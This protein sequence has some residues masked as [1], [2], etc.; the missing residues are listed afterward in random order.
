MVN[1]R[2]DFE[3]VKPFQHHTSSV[4]LKVAAPTGISHRTN[5]G[6]NSTSNRKVFPTKSSVIAAAA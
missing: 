4:L 2:N 6:A 3:S 5:N 1:L